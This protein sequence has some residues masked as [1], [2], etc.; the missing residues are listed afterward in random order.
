[1]CTEVI[2]IR[3]LAISVLK[4]S[5]DFSPL[6]PLLFRNSGQHH[7]MLFCL[8][9]MGEKKTLDRKWSK[10]T[11]LNSLLPKLLSIDENFRQSSN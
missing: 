9:H 2:S 8:P 6:F 7:S 3:F 10:K 5:I 1:M 11:S 4:K